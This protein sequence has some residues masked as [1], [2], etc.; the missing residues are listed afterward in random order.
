M[1]RFTSIAALFT[2]A[3][4]QQ[5]AH[6]GIPPDEA[7]TVTVRFADLDL[8]HTPGAATMY[9][10]LRHAVEQVCSPLQGRD[11]GK[12]ERFDRCTAE[13]MGAS[14][15]K[16]NRVALTEYYRS[17]VDHHRAPVLLAEK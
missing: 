15:A 7:P 16:V 2:L 1:N 9:R 8:D 5:A 12:K 17:I 4:I 14:I 6:A 3:L 13:S 11:L 10:R